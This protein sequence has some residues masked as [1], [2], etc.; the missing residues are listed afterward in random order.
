[1]RMSASGEPIIAP[2]PKPMIAIPVAIP[3]LSGNHLM[4]VETGEMYPSPRPQPPIT[5]EPSHNSQIWCRYTPSAETKNPPPQQNAATTPA[6]RGPSRSTQRPKTAADDPRNTK[7]SVNIQPRVLIFQSP[8][9]GCVIPMARDSGSQNTLNP[10][11][12]PMERWIASAAG[13]TSQRL[14]PGFAMMRSLASS[15]AM[16]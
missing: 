16:R 4:S 6:L 5:P 3:R 8:E 2:P 13:G 11:A 1:M 15:P 7:N 9:A 12:I 14:K 10:Y